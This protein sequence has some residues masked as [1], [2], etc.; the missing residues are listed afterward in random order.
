MKLCK[1]WYHLI[2]CEDTFVKTRK[3]VHVVTKLTQN[4][5][6]IRREFPNRQSQPC[7]SEGHICKFICYIKTVLKG[8]KKLKLSKTTSVDSSVD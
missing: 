2:G 6:A 4:H 5:I 7:K 3:A 1:P 8:G